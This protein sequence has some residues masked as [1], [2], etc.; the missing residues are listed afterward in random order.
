MANYIIGCKLHH[1]L[2]ND[3]GVAGLIVHQQHLDSLVIALWKENVA[4]D[5]EVAADVLCWQC[6]RSQLRTRLRV[7]LSRPGHRAAEPPV[8]G[9]DRSAECGAGP[10]TMN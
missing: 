5:G 2:I 3:F 7:G 1:R 10:T 8:A 6:E 4:A 9:T